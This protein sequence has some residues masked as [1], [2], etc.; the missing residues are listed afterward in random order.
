[1]TVAPI[2]PTAI[3]KASG[4]NSEGIK[5][6]IAYDKSGLAINICIKKLNPIVATSTNIKASILRIP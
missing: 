5:P 6:L 2:I 1:M 3:Y 4:D